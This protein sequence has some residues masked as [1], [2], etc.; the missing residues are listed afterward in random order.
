MRD[1]LLFI[2]ALFVSSFL[3]PIGIIY[4]LG[5][6]IFNFLKYWYF[7]FKQTYIA[8]RYLFSKQDK[9]T[10][11]KLAHVQDL[12]WNVYAGEFLEDIITD[13]EN[14]QFGK[15][16]LTVSASV[17]EIE[18]RFKTA[19]RGKWFSKFLDF[20]FKEPNHCYNAWNK[21]IKK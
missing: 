10:L 5:K 2:G 8:F 19:K 3:I 7:V 15:G 16:D 14:T 4:N 1:L 18:S 20:L 12:M 17:G 13:V 6:S 21:Y 9:S 11:F